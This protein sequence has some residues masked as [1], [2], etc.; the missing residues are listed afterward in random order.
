M[1]EHEKKTN[2]FMMA[3]NFIRYGKCKWLCIRTLFLAGYYRLC[4]L[5]LTPEKLRK[6]WGKQGEESEVELSE[7]SYRYAGKV[8]YA[9]DMVCDRTPWESKCMVKALCAR[10]FLRRKGIPSTIYLGCGTGESGE[11]LAHAWVRCG[12]TYV[13]GGD[14]KGYVIVDRYAD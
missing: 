12:R 6:N 8:G 13:T 3:W 14:G 4:I 10:H 1:K 5:K 9:V 2:W 7:E 11:M